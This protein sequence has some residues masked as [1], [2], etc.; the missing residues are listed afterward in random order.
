MF[1]LR[2]VREQVLFAAAAASCKLLENAGSWLNV[3]VAYIVERLYKL[4]SP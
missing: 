2:V 3:H 1:S 4:E